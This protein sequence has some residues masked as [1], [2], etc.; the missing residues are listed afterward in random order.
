MATAKSRLPHH[1]PPWCPLNGS[2]W[3]W[4]RP[5][6][7]ACPA[8]TRPRRTR[9]LPPHNIAPPTGSKIPFT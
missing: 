4:E 9:N 2:G 7:K 6:T 1:G 5:S 8:R 3:A